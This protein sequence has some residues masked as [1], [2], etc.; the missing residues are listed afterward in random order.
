[1][2]DR[3]P[4]ALNAIVEAEQLRERG[5]ARVLGSGPVV[6]EIGF[7]RAELLVDLAQQRPD[8]SFLGVEVSR[9]RVA[10]A[11]RR[12]E[13][14]ELANVRLVHATAEFLLERVLPESCIAE[15]WINFPDPWPKKRHWKRR[16]FQSGLLAQLVRVLEPG[17]ALHVA[18]DH[19]GYAE[20]IDEAL[21]A[22]SEL[23]NRNAPAPWSDKRPAR[24]ETGF[25]S[26]WLAEGRR[27][28]YFEYFRCD[29]GGRR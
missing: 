16:L 14:A 3:D 8:A 12:V 6:L 21:A 28:A 9:K 15:C 5:L 24:R 20:W 19:A 18:T 27:I 10:K 13:R 4:A 2:S 1:M 11:G 25:E 22:V 29:P 26:Q 23:E 7:G 17:A